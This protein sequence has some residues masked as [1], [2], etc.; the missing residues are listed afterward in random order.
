MRLFGPFFRKE[1]VSPWT[2]LA[3]IHV[4][5]PCPA[6]WERMVGDERVRHCA[7]CNLNVYN[8]S[9]M[10][11][12]QAVKLIAEREGRLCVRFYRRSDG[13]ILTQDCPWSLR[14]AARKIT[15]LASAVLTAMIGVGFAAA[16]SKPSPAV[17]VTHQTSQKDPGL[18]LTVMDQQGAMVPN[19]VITLVRK[20]DK[21]RIT[22][23]TGPAGT[24]N[25][26][27]L[28]PGDYEIHVQAA[29]FFPFDGSVR[30]KKR[31]LVELKLTLPVGQPD[32][33]LEA[34][35][36]MPIT[37]LATAGMPG[38]VAP[39][40]AKSQSPTTVQTPPAAGQH[41]PMRQ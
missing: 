7:E 26:S 12:R 16:E 6:S 25:Q 17:S 15:R 19:A 29:G 22:G 18:K 9:A 3:G 39:V 30:V 8:L 32:I 1:P 27:K 20:S 5:A 13:T 28:A 37:E 2:S 11:E 14:V 36:G 23:L 38:S 33:S 35:A 34:T 21:S 10:T 31:T 40:P 24:L 4:A 41:S